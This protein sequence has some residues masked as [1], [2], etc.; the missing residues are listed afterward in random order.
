MRRRTLV[1]LIGASALAACGKAVPYLAEVP[2]GAGGGRLRPGS[3]LV[4][5]V[6]LPAYATDPAIRLAGADGALQPLGKAVWA[7]ESPQAVSQA[8]ASALAG[9]GGAQ[10]AA[11][12]W[13]LV[14]PPE[15]ELAVRFDRFVAKAAGAESGGSGEEAGGPAGQ[16][17]AS[18]QIALA[19]PSGRLR[20]RILPFSVTVPLAEVTPQ[21]LA[22]ARARA[23][24]AVAAEAARALS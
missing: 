23:I 18:G 4:R 21:G 2:S 19:A 1:A 8:L 16:F 24:A 9:H 20:E 10:V 17:V 22:N 12:P 7:D 14:A 11:E 3:V 13:P 15:I 5:D 6:V